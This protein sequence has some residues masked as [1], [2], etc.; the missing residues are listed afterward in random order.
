MPAD[1][2]AAIEISD[3]SQRNFDYRNAF[4]ST[5]DSRT[6]GASFFACSSEQ[7]SLAANIVFNITELERPFAAALRYCVQASPR[8]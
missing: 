5:P 4:H 7:T 1:S 6:F 2:P 8:S 3:L